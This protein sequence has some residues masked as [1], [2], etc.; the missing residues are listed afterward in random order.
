M[1]TI[2]LC[3]AS[4]LFHPIYSGGALR[5]KRYLPGL[6]ARGVKTT[7][8]TSTPTQ[9]RLKAFGDPDRWQD[10]VM[11]SV[12]PVTMVEDTPVYRL[13]HAENG[14]RRRDLEYGRAL[15]DFCSQADWRP[16]LVQFLPM[17]IW[18]TPALI[19]L[20]LRQ[21][22]VMS[23]YN[24]LYKQASS[25][26]KRQLQQ[27]SRQLSLRFIDCVIVNSSLMRE[28][29]QQYGVRSRIEVIPNGVDTAHFYP[30]A[31]ADA[32]AQLRR[33]LGLPQEA[34]VIINVGAVLP[35]KGTDLLLAAWAQLTAN[36]PDCH[37]VLVGPRTDAGNPE[38]FSFHQALQSHITA[39]GAAE[40]V[41]FTG[42]V[43][44]VADYLRA[45]DLF[46]FPSLR[47]GLPN[48]V[49][50][51]MATALPVIMTPFEGLSDELGQAN[52]HYRL[53]ERTPGTLAEA[54]RQLLDDRESRFALG[55]TAYQ[56]VKAKMNID[57]T[58]DQLANLYADV[59]KIRHNYVH[60]VSLESK[61]YDIR[62]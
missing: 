34:K 39:S 15:V 33:E 57:S 26:V 41:H 36:N 40:R 32:R 27:F 31:N 37:L 1:S 9:A 4:R 8:F 11:G 48:V 44:N 47:E 52:K 3:L 58:L 55:N 51:A 53:A 45:A 10:A 62:Q 13:S 5:F 38:F 12:L 56:W 60:G 28:K 18:Y 42:Q 24:L 7:V 49:L 61:P 43:T 46:V 22:P 30:A 23:V 54:M 17:Q 19:R 59:A 2:N 25:P 20:K 29:L 35:R 14:L 50:E 6:H 21:L 16:D